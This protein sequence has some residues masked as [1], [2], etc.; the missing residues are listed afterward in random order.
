MAKLLQTGLSECGRFIERWYSE[1]GKVWRVREDVGEQQTLAFN[2]AMRQ[3]PEAVKKAD[4]G[5]WALS[6]PPDD[7][8][9][10]AELFPGIKST[11]R[12][13]KHKEYQRFM[14]SP[15]SEPYRVYPS[16]RGRTA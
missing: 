4:W 1:D 15:L 14:K 12:E 6:I 3:E 8:E 11:D 13:I 16:A 2:K 7:Y 5:R 10:I 9:M